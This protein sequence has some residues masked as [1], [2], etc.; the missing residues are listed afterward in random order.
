MLGELYCGFL[1]GARR[2]A[3]RRRLE[4]FIGAPSVRLLAVTEET[5][6][7]YAALWHDL[8]AAGAPV[9]TNDLWIAASAL[10]H[11]L[12]LLTADR[13]FERVPGLKLELL[14]L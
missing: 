6:D 9:P 8:R 3:N 13:H 10:E 4:A 11:D 2:E 1:R 12:A 5:A 7:H 14:E